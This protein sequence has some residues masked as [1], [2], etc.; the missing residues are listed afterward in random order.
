[1]SKISQY[2]EGQFVIL[3][4]EDIEGELHPEQRAIIIHVPTEE[5]DVFM[6]E[7]F[8]E[9]RLEWDEDGICEIQECQIKGLLNE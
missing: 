5:Y 7:I 9:D 8:K 1:M 6:V 2:E 3:I 4:A